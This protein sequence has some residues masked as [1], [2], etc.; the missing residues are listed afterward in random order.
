L[1]L[2]NRNAARGYEITAQ[3]LLANQRATARVL[4]RGGFAGKEPAKSLT[5]WPVVWSQSMFAPMLSFVR[6]SS[7]KSLVQEHVQ[8]QSRSPALLPLRSH[9][10]LPPCLLAVWPLL[11]GERLALHL[12]HFAKSHQ[13]QLVGFGREDPPNVLQVCV[14]R[15]FA[16]PV[17]PVLSPASSVPF[18]LPFLL[19]RL[20]ASVS[21][22]AWLASFVA[23]TPPQQVQLVCRLL[24]LPRYPPLFK[25]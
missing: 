2:R 16:P 10:G 6:L 21:L 5:S 17:V 9:L 24:F 15:W 11:P 3:I 19:P 12:L 20:P 4:R 7:L 8:R 18:S 14:Q 25:T 22:L 13:L 23:S 1:A